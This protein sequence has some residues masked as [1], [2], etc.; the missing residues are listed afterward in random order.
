MNIATHFTTITFF[1]TSDSVLIGA[2]SKNWGEKIYMYIQ[3]GK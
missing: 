3:V 1:G 2:L